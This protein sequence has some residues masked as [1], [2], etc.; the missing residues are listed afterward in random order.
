[1]GRRET[2]FEARVR[3][4]VQRNKRGEKEEI[5]TY[6]EQRAH[7]PTITPRSA[8]TR[9]PTHTKETKSRWLSLRYEI[10]ESER[11]SW[12]IVAIYDD[13]MWAM[14]TDST[15]LIWRQTA[16]R[17]ATTSTVSS[18]GLCNIVR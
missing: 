15:A 16:L 2:H 9:A 3:R 18:K 12:Y 8:Q 14:S 5:F 11:C 4:A 1:M 17:V 10:D 7:E 6:G 13:C